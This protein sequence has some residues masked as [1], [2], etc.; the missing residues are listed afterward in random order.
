MASRWVK[1]EDIPRLLQELSDE[2]KEDNN[3]E[4]D[5]ESDS[6]LSDENIEV[7]CISSESEQSISEDEQENAF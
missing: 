3:E 6:D 7:N 5:L 1:Y 4:A 2:E